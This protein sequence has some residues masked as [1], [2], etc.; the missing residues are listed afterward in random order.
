MSNP[1]SELNDPNPSVETHLPAEVPRDIAVPAEIRGLLG[2]PPLLATEEPNQYY[3]LL[4]ALARQV[5]P[6][7]VIE[8]LWVKDIADLT[9]EILRYRHIKAALV[10][11]RFKSALARHLRPALSRHH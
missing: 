1:V 4:A 7:D 2:E 9:W 5:K 10:N 8:W 11:G 6:R 3:A